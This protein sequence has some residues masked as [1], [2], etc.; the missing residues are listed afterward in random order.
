[1]YDPLCLNY[2]QL[3]KKTQKGILGFLKA[4]KK[5]TKPRKVYTISISTFEKD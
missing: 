2:Y 3:Q 4:I 5:G 1:M